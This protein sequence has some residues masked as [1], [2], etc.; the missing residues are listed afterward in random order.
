MR[1][2]YKHDPAFQKVADQANAKGTT[3][4]AITYFGAELVKELAKPTP[5]VWAKTLH[6]VIMRQ[7]IDKI[8]TQR[9]RDLTPKF[10]VGQGRGKRRKDLGEA[11]GVGGRKRRDATTGAA[12]W[13]QCEFVLWTWDE[14]EAK[15]PE[16]VITGHAVERDIALIRRLLELQAKA[17]GAATPKQACDQL[18]IDV[19]E[20][21]AA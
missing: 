14:L 11:H 18:G 4:Q 16:Y 12:A 20:F 9:L 3:D 15:L 19:Y 1:N 7:G 21:V 10:K 6:A 8:L 17:P 2:G 5:A 13:E